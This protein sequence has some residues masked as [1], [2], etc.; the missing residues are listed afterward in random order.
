MNQISPVN[1]VDYELIDTGGFEKLERFGNYILRRPEPQAVWKKIMAEGEWE[2]MA[3]ATF[4]LN[5]SLGKTNEQ[6]ERGEWRLKPV[7]PEQWFIR[8]EYKGLKLR[9]RLGLTSFKHIG[10]FPEQSVNWDYVFDFLKRQKDSCRVLNLFAYTGGASLAA[11]AAGADVI[12]L[13]S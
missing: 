13:D 11:K 1:W 8:Y 10:I 6:G 4:A 5:K 3:H 2:T 7:M 9:F 12:H